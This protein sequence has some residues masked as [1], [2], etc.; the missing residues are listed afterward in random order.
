MKERIRTL[1]KQRAEAGDI[2]GAEIPERVV[3]RPVVAK[4]GRLR[5]E[6]RLDSL[7]ARA[8]LNP[9]SVLVYEWE[10]LLQDMQ[11]EVQGPCEHVRQTYATV[12]GFIGMDVIG[13]DASSLQIW[14]EFAYLCVPAARV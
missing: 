7:K 10:A 3:E 13:S 1:Q 12:C 5:C 9:A 11:D 6:A 2:D 14:T 4:D 8:T